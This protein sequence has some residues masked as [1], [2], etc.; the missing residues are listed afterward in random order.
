MIPLLTL[1]IA[2]AILGV[3]MSSRAERSEARAALN[4]RLAPFWPVPVLL[5]LALLEPWTWTGP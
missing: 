1:V 5:W 4:R 2:A 3:V